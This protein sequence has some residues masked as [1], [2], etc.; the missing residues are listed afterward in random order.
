MQTTGPGPA[1]GIAAQIVG[2]IDE[3]NDGNDGVRHTVVL[4]ADGLPLLKSSAMTHEQMQR[5]A[6]SASGLYSLSKGTGALFALGGLENTLVRLAGGNV[7]VAAVPPQAVLAVITDAAADLR[8]VGYQIGVVAS[9]LGPRLTP[10]AIA[11]LR[12]R[13]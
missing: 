3:F 9:Q 6:A 11:D 4:T 7:I 5:L 12:S 10:E 13:I 8:K 1:V 2:L